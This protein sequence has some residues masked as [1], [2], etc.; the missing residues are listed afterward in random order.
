MPPAVVDAL[1]SEEQ[2]AEQRGAI[3]DVAGERA[4]RRGLGRRVERQLVA[5]LVDV[6]PDP[7]DDRPLG[8]LGED[9]A[10]LPAVQHHVVRPLDLGGEAGR[11]LD[12]LGRGERGDERELGEVALGGRVEHHGDEQRLGPAGVSQRRPD[13]RPAAGLVIGHR[14]CPF[15]QP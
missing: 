3:V 9:P 5:G 8:E 12:R 10:D 4:Q 13:P 14:S 11:A 2:R 7:D 6:D 15:G 1:E